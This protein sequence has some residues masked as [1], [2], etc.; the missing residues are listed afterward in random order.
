MPMVVDFGEPNVLERERFERFE[1]FRFAFFAVFE[2]LEEFFE[3]VFVQLV[4]TTSTNRLESR[5]HRPGLCLGPL[6]DP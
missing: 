6:L 1:N 4:S 5:C 2:V 3:I